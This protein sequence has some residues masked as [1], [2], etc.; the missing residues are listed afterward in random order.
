LTTIA[1]VLIDGGTTETEQVAS[2]RF[3]L[4][5]AGGLLVIAACYLV[6]RLIPRFAPDATAATSRLSGYSP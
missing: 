5:L 2:L 4:T 3:G 6:P 1:I